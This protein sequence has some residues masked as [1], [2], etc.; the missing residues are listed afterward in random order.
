LPAAESALQAAPAPISPDALRGKGET[1]MLVDDEPGVLEVTKHMLT[2]YGY[3]V[4]T[5]IH[6]ADALA[7]YPQCKA[8]LG[9][10]IMDMMMPVMDGPNAI[11]ELRKQDPKLKFIAIS[12]LLAGD[13][14][15]ERIGGEEVA[16][17]SKPFA[18]EKLLVSLREVLNEA[19]KPEAVAAGV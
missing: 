8:R 15:Q 2:H 4:I 12:G 11:R 7:L 3:N 6:G 17:I 10:V 9:V 5:A 13:K 18:S 1:V 19:P 16:F 14:I